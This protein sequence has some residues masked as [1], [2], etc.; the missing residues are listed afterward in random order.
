MLDEEI[1][2]EIQKQIE[3]TN[4]AV[5]DAELE[6]ADILSKVKKLI[7]TSKE[8]PVY[9]KGLPDEPQEP[10]YKRD[11]K[12]IWFGEYPQT[13][14]TSVAI[15]QMG[16]TADSKGYFTSSYDNERYAKV[17]ATPCST[18]R[19]FSDTSAVTEGN[20][21]Y[22]KVEPI[23][24]RILSEGGGNAL[25]LCES[26]IANRRFDAESNN[27][28]KSEIRAWLNNEFY[29]SA[30]NA[31]QRALIKTTEVDNSVY[32]TG[33]DPNPNVCT[34]TSDKIFL[35]SFRDV[36][37]KAYGFKA[38]G[39]KSDTARTKTASDYTRAT[40]AYVN[41]GNGAWWLRSPGYSPYYDIS[42]Y[43]RYVYNYG[44]VHYSNLVYASYHGLV[45]ALTI[46]LD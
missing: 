15:A 29:N 30:F 31:V 42:L 13:I 18:G 34:N 19:T 8:E 1:L 32:S 4:N 11:G 46:S 3:K 22:F 35:P 43:A 27:Y 10:T 17:V 39:S 21:Y 28:A 41:S 12:Y 14:A 2:I 40:G 36:T 23:K 44:Y 6:L 38:N 9:A 37:N 25:I 16:T 26:I 7:E 20:T 33:N 5:K 45:P 24:W